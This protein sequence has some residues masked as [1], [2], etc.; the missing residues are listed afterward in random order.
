MRQMTASEASRNFSALLD[1]VEAGQSFV[2]TRGG[3]PIATVTGAP[4][5]TWDA[6]A[7]VVRR[8]RADRPPD[9]PDARVE[10]ALDEI[11][12]MP[13][14]LDDQAPWDG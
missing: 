8:H 1:A 6:F 14:R 9:P 7:D 10:R 4:H 3:K 5:G 11:R 13:A 2:V 12:A